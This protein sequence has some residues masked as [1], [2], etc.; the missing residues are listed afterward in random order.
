MDYN[1]LKVRI[2]GFF[3]ASD[4]Y[5]SAQ[6]LTLLSSEGLKPKD[7]A[8]EMAL[9]RYWRQGLLARTRRQRRFYYR[10]TERGLGRREWL[11]KT[12]RSSEA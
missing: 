9:L 3:H 7:K 8:V 11:L 1:Q 6:I 4:E 10:L 12:M 2:L 5:E